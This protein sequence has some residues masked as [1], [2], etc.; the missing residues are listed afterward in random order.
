VKRRRENDALD[1][2]VGQI[3][4]CGNET[5]VR[6]YT[7][8]MTACIGVTKIDKRNQCRRQ[9]KRQASIFVFKLENLKPGCW[10]DCLLRPC[11]LYLRVRFCFLPVLGLH[12]YRLLQLRIAPK[13]AT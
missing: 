4:F 7:R 8:T 1:F 6:R 9:R 2:S 3:Q 5:A 12:S 13:P 11:Q 10:S